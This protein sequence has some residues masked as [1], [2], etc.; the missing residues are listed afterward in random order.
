[1][2]VVRVVPDVP[3][4]S[5]DDG[6]AYRLSE[7]LDA[8]VGAIVR[9][10]LGGRR[11]R[12]WVVSAGE[13]ERP[14]LKEVIAVSGDIPV[15][16]LRLLEVLRWAASR[17]VAPLA[18]LLAKATPPNLPRSARDGD[19]S[20]DRVSDGGPVTT[21][22]GPG[23]WAPVV[24]PAV[25]EAGEAG[26]TAIVIASTVEEAEAL[27]AAARD[28]AGDRVVFASSH[29]PGKE[30]T[31]AWVAAA[32][33]PGTVLVGTRE[34]ALWPWANPGVVILVGEGRVG[35]KDKATPT[36]HVRDVVLRRRVTEGF[37][38]VMCDAVPSAEAVTRSDV[39]TATGRRA[40]GL[41]E[42]VDRRSDP[43]GSGLLAVTTQAA[44]RASLGDGRRALLFTDRRIAAQRCV[45]CRTLRRCP[46][47]GAGPGA[48]EK[49]PRCGAAVG[50][51]SQCGGQRFEAL[52]SAAPSVMA[53]AARIVGRDVVGEVG[54]GRPILVGTER[55]LPGLTVDLTVVV[56][57]DGPLL[58]PNYRAGEDAL[59][60]LGRA[61]AAAGT[62]RGRRAIVQTVDPEH[63]VIRA[64]VAGEPL[65]FI[66]KDAALRSRAGFPPGGEIVVVE[67]SGLAPE[68]AGELVEEVGSRA[69][70]HGPAPEGDGLR[71]LVQG[72]D[73][74][75]A[76]T[77][78][79]GVVGR[80]RES[81][82]RVRVDADPIEL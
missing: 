3:S 56:D 33:V 45:R 27:A 77:V 70:V 78:L 62:G 80:W 53:E 25:T 7:G 79:R 40:W 58:A 35:M 10:P 21:M 17:Y 11:V 61:V 36:V 59:R 29:L 2:R 51:C 43:P 32:T 55:D 16:D 19:A 37:R 75:A 63:P 14:R 13:P 65:E 44:I 67:V 60:M 30:V 64:L 54:S 6:F 50:A 76:R 15:F 39:V 34:V 66:R 48:T 42:V 12:G 26:L 74:T 57:A 28:E 46:N 18:A 69:E 38:V 82:A 31:A 47:C 72:R 22:V 1:M 41:V 5:V 52:G 68:E 73:L 8:G 4:F 71:W 23:P 20:A 24:V 49:C 9:V 81:G